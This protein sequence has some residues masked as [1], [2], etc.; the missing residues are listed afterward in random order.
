MEKFWKGVAI[1]AVLLMILVVGYTLVL[2]QEPYETET[3]TI[4]EKEEES[5][6][7]FGFGRRGGMFLGRGGLDGDRM[8]PEALGDCSGRGGMTR[9]R[10]FSLDII[11]EALDL[12]VDEVKTELEEGISIA[13]LATAHDVDVQIIIDAIVAQREEA[14]A[15]AVENGRINQ[16]QADEM[17]ANLADSITEHVN[18]PWTDKLEEFGHGLPDSDRGFRTSQ[19]LWLDTVVN[20]LIPPCG[21]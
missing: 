3:P 11:A 2:A 8:M 9:R 16:E 17:L 7:S 20:R 4:P 1:G 12:T 10:E 6:T 15:V 19:I 13:D 21:F 5:D 18:T 14:M